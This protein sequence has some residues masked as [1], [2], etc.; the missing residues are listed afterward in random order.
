MSPGL[1]D[2]PRLPHVTGAI[3]ALMI[4]F[5]AV[6]VR[7]AEVSPSTAAVF[8]CA[9]ALPAL[10]LIA[11]WERRRHGARSL[12]GRLPGFAAGLFFA[13][14]L[15]LWHHSIGYIGAGLATVLGNAQVVLVGLIAWIALRERPGPAVLVA[16]PVV[17]AGGVLISGV[18]GGGA[19][20]DDPFLGAVYG[21]LTGVAYTGFIL[22]LRHGNADVRRPAGPLFDASLT[23]ALGAALAGMV[24]GDLSL[25]VHWPAH[26]WLLALG[27]T[28]Q[29][30]AWLL[31]SISLPRLPAAVTSVLLM[32]QPVGSV[33][34]GITLLDETPSGVQ[35]AGVA[36]VLVGVLLA[37]APGRR[38]DQES[39]EDP[40]A[41]LSASP[42]VDSPAS[43]FSAPEE[44]SSAAGSSPEA[45]PKPRT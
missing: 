43:A 2:H 3:G 11:L 34:L 19:Y 44:S 23:G 29:V 8:R 37:S 38:R 28:S 21:L 12:R 45:G 17:L 27:L 10:G 24:G 20:G 30:M 22:L 5:S 31:I 40:L 16:V 13:A 4:A 35:L 39:V 41:E 42:S 1:A 26:G 18:V 7:L 33:I 36:V 6:F 14:D 32:L 9:Y 25:A 15:V